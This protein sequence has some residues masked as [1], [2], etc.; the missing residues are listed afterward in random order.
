MK[1]LIVIA[2]AMVLLV[3]SSA[4]LG[5]CGTDISQEDY[6][7]VVAERD[8]A[9]AQVVSLEVAL[10]TAEAQVASLQAAASKAQDMITVL[11][12]MAKYFDVEM[13][14]ADGYVAVGDCVSGPLGGIGV[15]YVRADLFAFPVNI[16]IPE[17]LV[18]VPTDEGMKLVAVEYYQPYLGPEG[19]IPIFFGRPLNL[20]DVEHRLA[21]DPLY[22]GPSHWDMHVWLWEDNPSGIFENFNPNVSCPE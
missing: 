21:D 19:P 11:Q 20:M 4:A 12:V 9:E 15:H 6:D 16:T 14:L 13:A 22:S 2:L 17:M 5:A 8:A 18:Y 10:D 3:V 7:A 1:K